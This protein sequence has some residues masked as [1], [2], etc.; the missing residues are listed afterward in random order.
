MILATFHMIPL[1]SVFLL[2]CTFSVASALTLL[3][4][5]HMFVSIHR[6]PYV[7]PLL[8]W[9]IVEEGHHVMSVMFMNA[10]IMLTMVFAVT[11]L[12]ICHMLTERGRFENMLLNLQILLKADLLTPKTWTTTVTWLAKRRILMRSIAMM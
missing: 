2:A 5:M 4:V 10:Q 3:V 1:L 6:L 11:K 8:F 12:A 7:E 9:A